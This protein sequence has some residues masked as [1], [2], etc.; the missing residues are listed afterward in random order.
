[1]SARRRRSFQV[2]E[3]GR[4]EAASKCVPPL[5]KD[6]HKGGAGRI[7]VLGGSARYAGA[8]CYA[9]LAALRS[10]AD[11][12][13]VFTAEEAATPLKC[14]SP[15]L[16]VQP[17]YRAA[18]FDRRVRERRECPRDD[19]GGGDADLVQPMVDAVTESLERVHCLVVGPGMGRCP[20]AMA[21]AARIVEEARR[22]NVHMVLDAD[23]LYMLAQPRHRAL[24]RGYDRAVLTPNAVEYRRLYEGA[25]EGDDDPFE[26]ATIVQK[27]RHDRIGVN[28]T[29]VLTCA[30]EG[31]LKR[32]GGIG[33]VLSGA[34]GTLVAWHAILVEQDKASAADLPLACWTAC[35]LVK[36][37]TK[38]A[39]RAKR[40]A[41]S[42][43]DVLDELGATMDEMEAPAA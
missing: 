5:S 13:T 36:R 20:L 3:D 19:G 9:A 2:W 7:A 15:E 37:A 16:M 41:M 26:A 42:A 22:R 29:T 1:M 32:S 35:C 21:A 34:L 30:E 38:R 33:D 23:A 27:G 43:T 12:A 25:E 28:G 39:F 17:V 24:L 40:R 6:G 10:G 11:L 18:E 31:G 4:D 8:P 14:Y